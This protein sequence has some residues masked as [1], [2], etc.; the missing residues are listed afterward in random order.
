MEWVV[1]SPDKCNAFILAREGYDVWMGNNRGSKYGTYHK[2]LK[3]DDL[4]FW[5]FYQEDMGRKDLPAFI[6]TVLDKT[7][8]ES[9]SYVGHSEGTTQ[10]FLG[11]SL[12]P[13]YFKQRINVSVLLAPVAKTTH[14]TTKS[15]Q[16][17]APF[18]Y[19]VEKTLKL[20]GIYNLLPPQPL[21]SKVFDTVCGIPILKAVC[22]DIEGLVMDREIMNIDR[23]PE[24]F[25]FMPSGAGYRTFVY[26]A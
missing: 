16:D 8:L 15:I 5:D 2:T 11:A 6:D 13:D 4:A 25:S 24:F 7:G 22:K 9:I 18:V 1:N 26:Y 23:M 17:A 3:T 10:F 14:I 20:L 12:F 21:G 19:D